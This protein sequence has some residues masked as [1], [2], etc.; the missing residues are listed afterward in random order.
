MSAKEAKKGLSFSND[1][2]ATIAGIAANEIEGIFS[3]SG[4]V[5]DGF[6]ERLGRKSLSKGVM[7]RVSEKEVAIDL[8]VIV[9]FGQRVPEVYAQVVEHVENA[10]HN[11]TGLNVLEVNMYV[12]G[13][14]LLEDEELPAD[15]NKM[16]VLT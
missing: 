6:A 8:R 2:I 16:R 7:V 14:S 4:G 12:E 5:V 1:V 13:V 9:E 3:M 11:M 10:I 15:S